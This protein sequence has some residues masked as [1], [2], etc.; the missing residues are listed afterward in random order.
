[1]Q[2]RAN[3]FVVGLF[4]IVLTVAFIAAVAWFSASQRKP[5][6]KYLVFMREPVSGLNI[7]AP[8]RFNGVDVGYVE[9]IELNP[10]DPREVMMEL[11]VDKGTP[12]NQSTTATLM[13]QG[14][15]GITYIGLKAEQA[16]APP[17]K[18]TPGYPYPII[19]SRPSLFVRVNNALTALS[20]DLQQINHILHTLFSPE[21]QQAIS[22][23]LH[24][25]NDMSRHL[26]QTAPDIQ[27]AVRNAGDTFDTSKKMMKS[28]STQT[29]PNVT[30][31][32]NHMNR[33]LDT[34]QQLTTALKNNPSMLLRGKAI[35]P[36]GP[37]EK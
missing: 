16:T 34:V 9:D 24:H 1:M 36:L 37:G 21:N 13:A 4:M 8:V 15:T 12:V 5:H 17:L 33:V 14:V 31:M 3:Y 26:A 10:K 6:D 35:E 25:L 27:R 19:P 23:T 30:Q 32:L 28:I 22:Q 20:T 11:N 7:Q 2:P 29:V 18:K